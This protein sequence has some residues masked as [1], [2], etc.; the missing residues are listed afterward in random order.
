MRSTKAL[1]LR[2][3]ASLNKA[4]YNHGYPLGRKEAIALGLPI[5]KPSPELE[6]LM[7]AVWVD[8]ETE[9]QM[10]NPFN[11]LHELMAQTNARGTLTKKVQQATY[12]PGAPPIQLIMQGSPAKDVFSGAEIDGVM[13]TVVN[14]LMESTRLASRFTTSGW[15]L[16]A[17]AVDLNVALNVLTQSACWKPTPPELPAPMG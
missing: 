5:V 3:A 16:G 8:I 17:R 7:W 15:I 12:P 2:I 11:P 6:K 14:A 10:R 9:L 4:F 13:F 1:S